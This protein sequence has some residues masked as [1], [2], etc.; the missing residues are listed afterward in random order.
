MALVNCR[1]CDHLVSTEAPTCPSCGVPDPSPPRRAAPLPPPEPE[2]HIGDPYPEHLVP[3]QDPDTKGLLGARRLGPYRAGE[4]VW[5]ERSQTRGYGRVL[6][7]ST[8]F[9]RGLGT[10]AYPRWLVELEGGRRDWFSGISIRKLSGAE[11]KAREGG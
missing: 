7:R 1:E 10:K 11:R 8:E 9:D 3:S 2:W 6:D 4:W 5:V